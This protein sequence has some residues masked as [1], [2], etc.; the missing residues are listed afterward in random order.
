M[1]TQ[2]GKSVGQTSSTDEQ[3][4]E[5]LSKVKDTKRA[6]IMQFEKLLREADPKL[7][8][9]IQAENLYCGNILA[10]TI[11]IP[12]GAQLTGEIAKEDAINIMST[13]EMLVATEDGA[14]HLKAPVRFV[15]R[16]G[17]KKAGVALKDTV[18]TTIHIV[19]RPDMS[20]KELREAL[21]VPSYDDYKQLKDEE[22]CHLSQQQS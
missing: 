9:E 6:G 14:N 7:H 1:K 2:E 19:D 13:G 5:C 18:W 20:E 15:G 4:A 11:F 12:E 17:L 8:V 3:R 21:T 22:T 16:A 10:R